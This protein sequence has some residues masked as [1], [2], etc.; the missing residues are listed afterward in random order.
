MENLRLFLRLLGSVLIKGPARLTRAGDYLDA[1]NAHDVERVLA[2]TGSGSY[3]DP[4]TGG[5]LQG[6]AL[7][8]HAAMLLKAFPDLRF[9]LD[10]P[11]TAG[12][13]TVAARY[14][15]HATHTG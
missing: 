13:G 2:L 3:L 6:E 7:R 12:E 8:E 10:G 4:L 11:I 14:V 9:E 5:E 1:W 15:L